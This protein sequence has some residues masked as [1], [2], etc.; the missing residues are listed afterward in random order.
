MGKLL[1]HLVNTI[2]FVFIWFIPATLF[3][4]WSF[5]VNGTRPSGLIAIG[6]IVA[7][8][9]SYK[10]VKRIK[11]LSYGQGYLMNQSHQK[12]KREH[13]IYL[14]RKLMQTKE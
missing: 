9:I 4:G 1:R 3:V 5:S 7:I 2:L 8:I 6:G 11:S 10:L 14:S 13:L 12:K